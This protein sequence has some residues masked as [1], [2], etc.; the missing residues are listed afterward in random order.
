MI[1]SS[2]LFI[3]DMNEIKN[4]IITNKVLEQYTCFNLP[5]IERSF[6][7]DDRKRSV[8]EYEKLYD[9]YLSW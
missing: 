8:C 9:R 5:L 3:L 7:S 2:L 6:M 4:A 1:N